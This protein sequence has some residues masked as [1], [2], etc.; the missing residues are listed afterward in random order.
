MIVVSVIIPGTDRSSPR[1][2][3]T[4]VWPMLA[5]ASTA[6]N[7]SMESSAL[8]LSLPG[9]SSG[10]MAKSR[11][12]AS[13]IAEKRGIRNGDP[14]RLH[15]RGGTPEASSA[16]SRGAVSAPLSGDPA[17]IDDK[18]RSVNVVG[19][20]GQHEDDV[21]GKL[22][23]AGDPSLRRVLDDPVLVPFV[24]VEMRLEHRRP[25]VTG[26]HRVHA[27]PERRELDAE[28]AAQ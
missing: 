11:A 18:R 23:G 15:G 17:A 22:L 4:S 2:W 10:P 7:G 20:A 8:W 12:V 3:I 14:E 13:Q 16:T 27:D 24:R 19:E 21:G 6:A 5:I 25:H 1:C 9:A 28:R 26:D